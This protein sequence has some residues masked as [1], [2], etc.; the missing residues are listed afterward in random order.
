[1]TKRMP[2][3]RQRTRIRT[4][5]KQAVGEGHAG[6][7]RADTVAKA[8]KVEPSVP[9]PQPSMITATPVSGIVAGPDEDRQHDGVEG[10]ALLRHA[11]AGAA[12]GEGR[13]QDRDHPDL[14]APQRSEQPADAGVD[15]PGLGHHRQEPADDQHEDRHV[16]G[17]RHAGLGVVEPGDRRHQHRA[18]P[19]RVRLDL[20]VGA[21]NRRLLAERLV[22]ARARIGRPE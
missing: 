11:V 16:D 19:L 3:A 20:G 21:R 14:A 2:A 10:E 7:V 18:E 13:H 8:L 4:R 1:M 5:N 9:M 17:V 15:R 12:G 22:H 6:G